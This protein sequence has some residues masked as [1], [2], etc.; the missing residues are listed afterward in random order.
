MRM[1]ILKLS[2]PDQ[3][4]IV[5]AVS[6]CLHK[7][8]CNIEEAAQF[9]ETNDN[10]FFM[11]IIFSGEKE[12]F[13]KDFSDISNE[14]E[15]KYSLHDKETPVKALILVSQ[16]DH[17]LNDLLYRSN[18][19]HLNLDI[20]G[21]VSNHEKTREMVEQNIIPF[22][23]VDV[24]P[25]TKTVSEEHIKDLITQTGTDLI[26]LARYMQI[27]SD[28]FCQMY[29]AQMINIHHSFLPGFKGAKPY[30]QAYKRGVKMIGATA[31]FVTADLDE[32]PII[33]QGVQSVDH[34]YTPNMMQA[35]GRDI[36]CQTLA[37]AVKLHS[38]H[39]IFL[40]NQRTIIL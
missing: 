40:H 37:K 19:Q 38:E 32:G 26:I 6:T 34:T 28:D 16:W 20:T 11:R 14:F 4:G 3:P 15:M 10:H 23:K 25:E 30:H 35:L 18:A 7:N 12:A 39:R 27:L 24:T 13:L 33:S 21:V 22:H 1:Y 36:E 17:C 5:S 8:G 9:H 29:T 2:C 31:H